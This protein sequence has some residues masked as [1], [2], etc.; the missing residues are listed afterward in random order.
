MRTRRS[1][2][3]W[4]FQLRPRFTWPAPVCPAPVYTT[5]GH[6]ENRTPQVLV[7]G[8]HNERRWVATNQGGGYWQEVFVPP[9]YENRVTQVWIPDTAVVYERP[10]Y[11]YY[12][13]AFGIGFGYSTYH[14]H[15]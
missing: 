12:R 4:V 10:V 5:G 9:A 14:R 11:G 8:G 13:P 15:W 3:E 2:S 6:Y 7:S 1:A